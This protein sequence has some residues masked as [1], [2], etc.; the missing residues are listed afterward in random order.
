VKQSKNLVFL[1]LKKEHIHNGMLAAEP[2]LPEAETSPSRGKNL[3]AAPQ[4]SKKGN[5][6][7][8]SFLESRT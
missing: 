3:L 8:L 1:L 5:E 4:A 7:F 2:R 6:Y